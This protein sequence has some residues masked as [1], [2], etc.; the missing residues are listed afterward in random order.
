M[1][2]NTK[3]HARRGRMTICL[4]F[5]GVIHHY[6]GGWPKSGDP[7]DIED[8]PTPG[9]REAVDALLGMGYDVKCHSA[10][11]HDSAAVGAIG[12]YLRKH[13]IRAEVVD[14]KP[15]S[16]L[17][18]DDRGFRF[19][20]DWGALL[21]FAEEVENLTPWNKGGTTEPEN[22]TGAV[23]QAL[24]SRGLTVHPEQWDMIREVVG[25]IAEETQDSEVLEHGPAVVAYLRARGVHVPPDM[26]DEL[27]DVVEQCTQ[28]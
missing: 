8:T 13:D 19:R 3:P 21:R 24:E 22:H 1:T 12:D 16:S 5:D 23:I 28:D 26:V 14:Q 4:D 10:R 27:H 9:A 17:Y 15:P 2:N 25:E 18:V 6:R 7:R 11:C 20:G